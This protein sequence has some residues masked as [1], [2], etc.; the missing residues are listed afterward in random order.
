VEEVVVD[1]MIPV[2][3]GTTSPIFAKPHGK[4]LWVA[5]L[6]KAFAKFL[7]N[8]HLLD[9]GYM[10]YGLQVLTGDMVYRW[11]LKDKGRVWQEHEIRYKSKSDVG[12]WRTKAP[13]IK[14]P[15]FFEALCKWDAAECVGESVCV[16][17][18]VCV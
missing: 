6:E 16:C 8:Y 18:C 10:L 5:L 12:F 2:E 3:A 14:P 7:G 17:V 15:E 9:G 4:E 11:E 1:D 13:G